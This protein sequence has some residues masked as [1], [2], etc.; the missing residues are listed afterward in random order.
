MIEVYKAEE[1]LELVLFLRNWPLCDRFDLDWVYSDLTL[2]NDKA[3]IWYCGYIESTFLCF[4]E[5]V[6]FP[7]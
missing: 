1:R 2:F 3:E 4:R 7:E 6:V 5:E